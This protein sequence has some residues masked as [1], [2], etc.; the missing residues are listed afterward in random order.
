MP[1]GTCTGTGTEGVLRIDSAGGDPRI[2]LAGAAIKMA[3]GPFTLSF[4]MKST[5]DAGAKIYYG[6]PNESRTV[7]VPIQ[8]DGRWHEYSATVPVDVLTGLRL[9]PATAPGTIDVDWLRL[10]DANG[11]TVRQWDF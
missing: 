4:R 3:S 8:P 7:S 6:A 1:G 5:A 10:D 2:S 9:D 11:K